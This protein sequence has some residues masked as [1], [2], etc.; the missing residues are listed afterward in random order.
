M[1]VLY[2]KPPARADN[3]KGLIEYGE[4]VGQVRLGMED[5]QVEQALGKPTGTR[6]VAD[7][8]VE[9]WQSHHADG[10][11]AL[12]VVLFN[13]D[14][15]HRHWEA[16]EV[17]VTSPYFRTKGGAASGSGTA[18]IWQEFP[19]LR[20]VDAGAGADGSHQELYD[21]REIGVGFLI[22]R[23]TPPAGADWGRCRGIVVHHTGQ[24]ARFI[25][26]QSL[27]KPAAGR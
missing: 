8:E 15:K 24:D 13:Q 22:E 11:T 25:S 27:V 2:L 3:D 7:T 10:Q 26:L 23:D 5:K 1:A 6:A 14:K 9:S 16:T 17:I 4:S 19:V 12:T 20:Y 18:A 21:S